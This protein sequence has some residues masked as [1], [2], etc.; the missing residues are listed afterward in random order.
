MK[1]TFETLGDRLKS[2]EAEFETEIGIDK[3]IIVRIDGHKFS[4]YTKGFNRPFDEILSRAMEETTKELVKEFQA[5]VG[6]TQSDE[7]TL[8]LSN[9]IS[10]K[11]F[12]EPKQ[13]TEHHYNG[14]VQK[15]ASLT[16]GFATMA[17]NRALLDVSIDLFV[18]AYDPDKSTQDEDAYLSNLSAK[19]AKAW[20]DARVYAVDSDIEAFN[21]VLW[22]IRDAEKNS[23]SMFAQA[24]CKHKDLQK[25]TGKEQVQFCKETTGND[26]DLVDDRYKYGILVKKEK[27]IK[28]QGWDDFEV[29]PRFQRNDAVERTRL[30]SFSEK[31]NFSDK[32]VDMIMAK[33][34]HLVDSEAKLFELVENLGEIKAPRDLF[35]TR[36]EEE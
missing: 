25:M 21:S 7:I 8:V 22:R 12:K 5:V 16:A 24:Y 14:R 29:N 26:Y 23:R 33:T 20:F 2:Y 17:F 34:I 18:D 4:K 15:L 6:Y 11:P 3:H 9:K 30:V 32:N 35:M 36:V 10:N 1:S 19:H 27:Y 31:L 28:A 13:D